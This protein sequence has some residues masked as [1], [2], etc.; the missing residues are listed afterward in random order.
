MKRDG[1]TLVELLIVVVLGGLVLAAI[2]QVLVSNQQI[3][4]RQSQAVLGQQTVRGGIE[5][6][7]Q[8]IRELSPR[9]NDFVDTQSDEL[10][11]R[12]MRKTAV[13]CSATGA[14]ADIRVRAGVMG[15][16]FVVGDS[17]LVFFNPD[18]DPANDAFAAGR[19]TE[20]D[21]AVGTGVQCGNEGS[22]RIEFDAPVEPAAV[23]E[24]ALIRSFET[25][26]YSVVTDNGESFLA[27]TRGGG[28]AEPLL[29]PIAADDGLLF[30][31][32]DADGEVIAPVPNS[33]AG[34]QAIR[35][36]RVTLRT[37]SQARDAQGQ[38]IEEALSVI[39]NP[40]N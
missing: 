20:I 25:I 21:P 33:V 36:V 31:Y 2:F 34:R 4:T 10:T 12:V 37:I 27:R 19:V 32:L 24:G 29:G 14:F 26:T 3:Y 23:G 8:E 13:T 16:Q 28:P 15:S 39:V 18:G 6:L 9:G 30:E 11:V 22:Q 17:V 40:R 1:F 38:P 5:Y 35:S 7:S